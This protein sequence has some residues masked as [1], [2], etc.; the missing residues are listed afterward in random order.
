MNSRNDKQ[1]DTDQSKQ[2]NTEGST[3]NLLYEDLT[4]KIRKCIF[5]VANKYGKGLKEN[6]YQKA[7][8]EELSLIRLNF[9]E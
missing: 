9:D 2:I 5:N 3:E 4:F 8:A 7:L 1:M 6:I